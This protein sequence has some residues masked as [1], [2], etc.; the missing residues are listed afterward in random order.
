M[1]AS[2]LAGKLHD[3]VAHASGCPVSWEQNPRD[4]THIQV[5]TVM[6]ATGKVLAS[7]WL[8]SWENCRHMSLEWETGQSQFHCKDCGR[9]LDPSEVSPFTERETGE[10]AAGPIPQEISSTGR[11]RT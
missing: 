11:P 6:S 4:L 5:K 7:L 3:I 9:H 10:K 8:E 2:T 1:K